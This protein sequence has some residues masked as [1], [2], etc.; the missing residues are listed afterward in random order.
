MTKLISLLGLCS[1]FAAVACAAEVAP[2]REA[3]EAASSTVERKEGTGDDTKAAAD[4]EA[5]ADITPAAMKTKTCNCA[6]GDPI[7]ARGCL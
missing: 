5:T 4:E 7:C 2:P 1:I 6:P 3:D